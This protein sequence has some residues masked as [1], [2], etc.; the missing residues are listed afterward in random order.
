MSEPMDIDGG[1]PAEAKPVTG[2]HLN[3]LSETHETRNMH[4][5]RHQDYQRYRQFCARKIA[6]LRKVGGLTQSTPKKKY[7]R[8]PVTAELVTGEKSLQILLFEAERAWAY[9]MEIK[10]EVRDEPRKKFHMIKRLKRGVEA[11]K[12]LQQ[13]CETCADERTVLDV[14]AYAALLSAYLAFE[15]QHWEDALNKFAVGR[16]IY[17]GLSNTGNSHQAT[18]AQSAIDGIDPSIKF[19]AYSLRISGAQT[20]E[21][22]KLLEAQDK[23]ASLGLDA[24]TAH[25]KNT[26]AE[27][28][29]EPVEDGAFKWRGASVAFK[30]EKIRQGMD[31]AKRISET[32]PYTFIGPSAPEGVEALPGVA[33]GYDMLLAKWTEVVALAKSD[34]REDEIAVSKVKSSKSDQTTAALRWVLVYATFHRLLTL[35]TRTN[36]K[37]ELTKQQIKT[38]ARG[39]PRKKAA[40]PEDVLR[41]YDAVLQAANDFLKYPEVEADA[42]LHSLVQSAVYV[43]K[44]ER[45]AYLAETLSRQGK[46]DEATTLLERASEHATQGRALIESSAR[47]QSSVAGEDD[48][49]DSAV[50]LELRKAV[51]AIDGAVRAATVRARAQSYLQ[52]KEDV[53]TVADGVADMSIQNGSQAKAPRQPLISNLD[54][55]IPTFDRTNPNLV[56][57][58][59][60]LAPVPYKPLFFDMA[61]NGIDF[62]TRNLA[63]RAEGAER[64]PRAQDVV[65]ETKETSG[66]LL[67]VLG[68]L[69]GRK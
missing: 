57:F 20:V 54:T 4:G 24:L 5:L 68:G 63:R 12:S 7:V 14:K 30:N 44:A 1:L 52:N 67:G 59:P 65:E 9:A 58:P 34:V 19:C 10:Q 21:I 56:S 32:R 66:G 22:E 25:V 42:G 38:Q 40:K 47:R 69:W 2:L 31:E 11:A 36:L 51:V 46:R 61:Y 55:Y 41:L 28:R 37:V 50:I 15:Q 35:L 6:R 29:Q 16:T 53:D 45:A 18:L 49:D 64:V 3:V 17:A 62:P 48:E 27:F 60:Q 13:L 23:K 43:I 8:K 33:D 26:L 39:T